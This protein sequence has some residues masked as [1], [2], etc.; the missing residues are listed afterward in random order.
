MYQPVVPLSGVAG[1]RFLERT[2]AAQRQAF[3]GSARIQRDAAYFQ[4]RI[5]DVSSARDLVA[6]RR[7]LAVALGAFGLD[8]DLYKT[9]FL[10]RMLSEGTDDPQSLANKFVDPRYTAFSKAFGFGDLGGPHVARAGFGQDIV[11]RY[12]ERQFE[13]AVGN[14]DESMRLAMTFRREIAGLAAAASDG[15]NGTQW[16]RIMGSNPLRSVV[17]AAFGLPARFAGLDVDRQREMLEDKT[18]RMFG[19]SSVAAFREPEAVD[20]IISR[21]LVRRQAE[22]GPTAGTPGAAAL[23]LLQSAG[24][25]GLTNLILSS[26]R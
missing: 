9:A 21:F 23:T 25:T 16:Y 6:D 7:M 15:A 3:E 14:S 1:W 13:I 5:A 4:E 11:A 10:E 26:A 17:E 12:K 18:S 2:E 22:A 20:K 24:S 19:T 8:D